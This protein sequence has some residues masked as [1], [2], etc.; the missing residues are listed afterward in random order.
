MSTLSSTRWIK[1]SKF[2]VH[3]L[4]RLYRAEA[5]REILPQVQAKGYAFQLEII[6]RA[7]AA[8][9]V[10]AEVP[11]V[12]VDRLFGE[13]K[14]AASEIVEFARGLIRLVFTL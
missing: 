8:G 2:A 13:S 9:L 4:C 7:R 14:L 1:S 10:V 6:A 11:I 3:A 5:L 12:F